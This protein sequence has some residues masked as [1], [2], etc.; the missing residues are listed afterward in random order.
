[1]SNNLFNLCTQFNKPSSYANPNRVREK[2]LLNEKTI[3][4]LHQ[5]I[6]HRFRA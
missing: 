6:Y 2:G 4:N 1:M 5:T 3:T